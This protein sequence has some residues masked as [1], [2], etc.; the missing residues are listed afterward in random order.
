MKNGP[1]E[2][3]Q[4]IP[5][6]NMNTFNSLSLIIVTPLVLRLAAVLGA[7]AVESCSLRVGVPFSDC[8]CNGVAA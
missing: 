4:S 1:A 2:K 5:I 3:P 7:V 8:L 6:K